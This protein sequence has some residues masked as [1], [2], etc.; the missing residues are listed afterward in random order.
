[1]ANEDWNQVK[2]IFDAA[3]RY[4]SDERAEFLNRAC[5]DEGIRYEVES[6]LSSFDHASRF[7]ERPLVGEL[8]EGVTIQRRLL[9]RGQL[10]GHYKIRELIGTGGM[11]AVYLAEDTRLKRRVAVKLINQTS[12]K[13]DFDLQRFF[14]EARAASAL[15]HPNIL[16]VYEIGQ[17]GDTHFIASE[18]IEGATLRDKF[19]RSLLGWPDTLDIAIQIASALS[20][21]H[22]SN[23]VHRDI[24]PENVMIRA[25]GLVKVLDFGLAKLTA[26]QTIGSED[27][28]IAQ[29]QTTPGL[30]MGTA[31]YMSPE[32]A[33]GQ[34]TDARTDIFSFGVLLYEMVTGQKP[35]SG[36][37]TSD[38]IASVLKTE[39]PPPSDFNPGIP[40]ELERIILTALRKNRE[41]RYQRVND[42]LAELKEL[43]Q[44]VE[45]DKKLEGSPARK[46]RVAVE[47]AVEEKRGEPATARTEYFGS[48]IQKYRVPVLAVLAIVLLGA[49]GVGYRFYSNRTVRTDVDHIESIVVLPFQNVTNNADAE[50]LSDGISE[51]LINSLTELQRLK[52]IA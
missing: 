42:L 37:T 2:E 19:R 13:K 8:A 11:G 49:I 1:M 39:A 52:V 43:K 17:T 7:M 23:I 31:A 45:F 48:D 40:A 20:A 5:T 12:D 33:R 6:L 34:D 30:I 22:S 32:Q 3:L 35:F 51:T 4:K 15:N 27:E 46:Q 21:S 50:Y 10:L 25:D 26:R 44:E 24:K 41:E 16:T 18:Y 36:E 28:T 29:I 38:L 9:T 47:S 14:Q